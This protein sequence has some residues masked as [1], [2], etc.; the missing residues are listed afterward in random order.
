MKAKD[1]KTAQ[2][3]SFIPLSVPDISGNEWKYVKE[4]LDTGWVSSAGPFVRKFEQCSAD[5]IGRKYAVACSSGTA[6]LHTA[7]LVLGIQPDEEVIVPDLTFVAPAFAVRYI[8]AWPLFMD[9]DEKYFQLDPQKLKDFLSKQCSFKRGQCINR[10]TKRRIR[11][12]LPVHLLGHPVEMD[13]ILDLAKKYGLK[14]IEDVAESLGAE[15]KRKKAGAFGDI[16]VLSFNGNKII[17]CGGGGMLLTDSKKFA[18]KASYLTTQA[19]DHPIEFVH[20]HIGYNYR[21]NNLQAAIGLAQFEQLANYLKKKN[22]I[23]N[24]YADSLKSVQGLSLPQQ[25]SWA[26]S[27]W[28]LY[29]ILVDRKEY[30]INSRSLMKVLESYNIQARPFWHPLHSLKAFKGCDAYK[31]EK[32]LQ[33]YQSGLSLPSSVGLTKAQQAK[34]IQVLQDNVKT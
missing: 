8:G 19:K 33:L 30:G 18:Q 2:L 16:A 17:T 24:D 9:V 15:Y 26:K 6:A 32:S 10:K 1:L 21:L 23:A 25:A 5:Y 34:V 14:I 11:A 20:N 7:L 22:N 3:N 13:P 28:W 29:T 12:I 4:C 27:I 31:I